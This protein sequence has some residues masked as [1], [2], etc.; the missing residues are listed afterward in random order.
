MSTF[1]VPKKV[2]N[3]LESIRRNLFNGIDRKMVWISWKNIL[4]SKKYGGLGVSSF[5]AFNCALLFKWVWR[6]LSHGSTLWTRTIKAIYGENGSLD[7]LDPSPIR[8]HWLDI[9]HEITVIR[10]KGIDLLPLIRK[11][12]RNR[13]DTLFWEDVWFDG[14]TL[15]QQ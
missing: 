4:A 7:F 15:K 8:S 9:V 5:F 1:K 12:M 2:L 13:E 11:K 14:I 6:F 3:T 10:S